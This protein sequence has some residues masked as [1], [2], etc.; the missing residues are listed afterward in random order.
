MS[1]AHAL[2]LFPLDSACPQFA[3]SCP[4]ARASSGTTPGLVGI[5]RL[6]A[7]SLCV[8]SKP[9]AEYFSLPVRS[10]LNRCDSERMPFAWT[11]NPYRGCE[12]GCHYCYARY[13][14]EYMELDTSAFES[15]IFVKQNAAALLARDL[16][17]HAARVTAPGGG[18]ARESIAMG[19]ATDPY[20]PAERE[21]GVTRALLEVI[22][23]HGGMRL[24][25]VT[26]SDLITRDVDVL[27]QIAARSTL[28][29][30]MTVTTTRPR[31]ARLLEPRA[32]RPDLR[33]HAL[34]RL[35]EA[36]L[37]AGVYASPVLPG[38][39]DCEEDLDALARAAAE[40]GALW[41]GGNALFLMPSSKERW[42]PF[43]TAKFPRLERHYRRWYAR[44]VYAPEAY[45]HE[46]SLRFGRLRAKYNLGQRPQQASLKPLADQLTLP[47]GGTHA[48]RAA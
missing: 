44:A 14:H 38:I 16:R 25:I 23:Q 24:A 12:F 2:P 30:H 17:E 20:Q 27:A 8:R 6:A 19:T 47:L 40:A 10:V 46:L 45:Q 33:L 11:I 7:S 3:A 41:F 43:L 4:E 28:Q 13:T 31:L 42:M 15:R 36:G 48:S 37:A 29:I 5:A 39:T 18:T 26:K 9:T 1:A 35:R 22:A 32:P 21:H 34:R